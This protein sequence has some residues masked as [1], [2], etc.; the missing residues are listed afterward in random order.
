MHSR[1]VGS[2]SEIPKTFSRVLTWHLM[3]WGVCVYLCAVSECQQRR[4]CKDDHQVRSPSHLSTVE[5]LVASS[6]WVVPRFPSVWS[7]RLAEPGSDGGD[8][9]LVLSSIW[10]GATSC[11]F[12][13]EA[14][15]WVDVSVTAAGAGGVSGAGAVSGGA[16]LVRALPGKPGASDLPVDSLAMSLGGLLEASIQE[17]FSVLCAALWLHISPHAVSPL[18]AA[19]AYVSA[20]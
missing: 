14:V 17:M 1:T 12:L 13:G 10:R 11:S 15:V 7:G 9:C 16:S 19:S 6:A 4:G 3:S 20:S 8:P 5:L 18:R 2:P